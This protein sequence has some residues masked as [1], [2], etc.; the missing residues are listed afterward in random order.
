MLS[1]SLTSIVSW[2]Q[3]D[4]IDRM[5]IPL[6][7][8]QSLTSSAF[9][10]IALSRTQNGVLTVLVLPIG[11]ASDPYSITSAERSRSL[12]QAGAYRSQ[13][14]Q[15]CKENT[16]EDILC[17][18]IL[19]PILTRSDAIEISPDYFSDDLSAV[20]I[21][22]GD[23]LTARQVIGGTPLEQALDEAY[24]KGAIITGVGDMG[25]ILSLNMMGGYSQGYSDL[26]ALNFGST[27][28][29]NDAERHGLL[30]G[31]HDAIIDQNFFLENRVGRLINATM[32]PGTP[33]KGI[34]IDANAGIQIINGTELLSILGGNPITIMDAET[35]HSA[36][37][38][39]YNGPTNTLS[40]R[41]MLIHV[42]APGLSYDLESNQ[43]SLG[44]PPQ[45]ISRSYEEFSLP[46]GS[47]PLIIAGD[48][49]ETLDENLVLE[50]FIKASQRHTGD[51]V[52]VPVGFSSI[53]E[54][55]TISRQFAEHL[56]TPSQILFPQADTTVDIELPEETSGIL[57]IGEDQ[58]I[59]NIEGLTPLRDLWLDGKPVLAI[60]A[61]AAIIGESYSSYGPT[62]NRINQQRITIQDSFIPDNTAIRPGLGFLKVAFEPNLLSGNRWGHLI[63]LA[64][65]NPQI[66]SIGLSDSAAIEITEKGPIVIGDG[67]IAAL[68]L[69]NA[70]LQKGE[71][72][73]LVIGNGLL[74]VFSLGDRIQPVDADISSE[75]DQAPTP[76][77]PTPTIAG[78][79]IITSTPAPTP[80]STIE[81]TKGPTPTRTKKPTATPLTIPPPANPGISNLMALFGIFITIVILFG[82]ALNYRRIIPKSKPPGGST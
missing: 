51:I 7:S 23:H 78:Y 27:D 10:D 56:E 21:L 36:Q 64:Y 15:S 77:L 1:A 2:A 58:S 12:N 45:H 46:Q 67:I 73:R 65:N 9:F 79:I 8:D 49:S 76:E 26:N 53:N 37:S 34:G 39:R 14:N 50:R 11:Y 5:L 6:G 4:D 80:T 54:A 47:G 61:G 20:V 68:D 70:S 35:Y 71:N 3:E 29:W 24:Q 59:V 32:L 16:P 17:N 31:V 44:P 25:N 60:N 38:V 13:I 82:I 75:P 57:L 55:E 81:P 52:I 74:D 72:G 18:V 42:L 66:L 33:D 63:S 22:D 41:N 69:R 62:P 19:A 43:T 28:V 30:F 48:I 40:M